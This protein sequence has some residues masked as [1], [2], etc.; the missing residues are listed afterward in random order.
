MQSAQPSPV[1]A[2]TARVPTC[3]RQT[4]PSCTVVLIPSR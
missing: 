1:K 3:I 2:P 4:T